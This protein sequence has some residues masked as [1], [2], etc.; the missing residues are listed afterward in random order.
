[1]LY[2]STI[3]LRKGGILTIIRH[4]LVTSLHQARSLF[5]TRVRLITPLVVFLTVLS[6]FYRLDW[7]P[8]WLDEVYSY[9]V[10]VQDLTHVLR[11]SLYDPHPPLYYLLLKIT[12]ISSLSDTEY[13]VRWFSAVCGAG[14]VL[15][16]YYLATRVTNHQSALLG[17]LIMVCSPA[18]LYYSQEARSYIVGLLLAALSTA[19]MW[20]LLGGRNT[21]WTWSIWSLLSILGFYTAYSYLIIFMSQAV[22]LV[23][24]YKRERA[25]FLSLFVIIVSIAALSPALLVN[26][27]Q[28]LQQA[29]TADPLTLGVLAQALLA[30]DPARYGLHWWSFGLPAVLSLLALFA[31]AAARDTRQ[32]FQWY[33]IAQVVVPLAVWFGIASPFL[34]WHIPSSKSRQFA[35]LIPAFLL[36]VTSGLW[37]CIEQTR[38]WLRYSLTA[39]ICMLVVTASAAAINEYW[40]TTKSPEG[41]V[42]QAIQQQSRP[43]EPIISLHYSLDA[44]ASFYLTGTRQVYN[45]PQQTDTG[46]Q[47]DENLLILSGQ[48]QRRPRISIAE[49]RSH[50]SFWVINDTRRDPDVR[51]ALI[52]GCTLDR[53]ELIGPFEALHVAQCP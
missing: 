36:L 50:P 12:S 39:I 10:S 13:S 48:T 8:L 27:R 38:T 16:V 47:F 33:L 5:R 26:V 25:L 44:A 32:V 51:D 37:W 4:R 34:G 23:G 35:V 11:N 24:M 41:L 46:Y 15:A 9:Q 31:L 19:V 53:R 3:R 20:H 6:R 18:V 17:W 45:A 43:D 2:L 40:A 21:L 1:M 49:V 22:F 28:D 29:A 14:A 52:Q 42:V 30:A 7:H